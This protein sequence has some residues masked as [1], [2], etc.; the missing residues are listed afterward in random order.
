MNTIVTW[1]WHGERA[2]TLEH[3]SVFSDLLHKTQDEPF[4]L[5]V[6]A[7]EPGEVRGATVIQTPPEALA[8][9]KVQTLEGPNFPSSYRRLWLF[10]R[11]AA[12]II[13]GD[14]LQV[15]V[16]LVPVS[17][18]SHLF[19]FAPDAKFVGW[20]PGQMWGSNEN[21]CGGGTWRL[22]MGS[23]PRVW[24]D[25]VENPPKAQKAAMAAGYRGSDQAWI[26]H[27]LA[28][29]CRYFPGAFGIDSIRDYTRDKR[30]RIVESIP[31][32]ACMVHFNGHGKPWHRDSWRQ[33]PWLKDYYP[34][35]A[36]E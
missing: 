19:R 20:K 24:T 18:W 14:V 10:S 32:T 1:I 35:D 27:M 12:E 21:R 28:R 23:H 15:D 5:F 34:E 25:F 30:D 6:I 7:D 9:S 13:Q 29:D 22:K 36:V 31:Q 3:A 8:M 17:D 2:Y 26:S 16:D 11:E 33:H 4:R